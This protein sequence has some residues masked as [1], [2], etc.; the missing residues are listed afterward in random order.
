M[1]KFRN[2]FRKRLF[3]VHIAYERNIDACNMKLM[4]SSLLAVLYL[5]VFV[6]YARTSSYSDVNSIYNNITGNY[7]KYLRPQSDQSQP[8]YVNIKLFLKSIKGL[9]EVQG[10]FSAVISLYCTWNDPNLVWDNSKYGNQEYIRVPRNL[11][12]SPTFLVSNPANKHASLGLNDL[13]VTIWDNGNVEFDT[14]E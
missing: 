5:I 8:T 2:A 9:D 11:V 13:P 4:T 7:N 10:V 12:W 6:S 3:N 1:L 14:G